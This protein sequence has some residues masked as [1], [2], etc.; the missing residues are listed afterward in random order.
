MKF[1]QSQPLHLTF[2]FI[3]LFFVYSTVLAQDATTS[4]EAM[5]AE[6]R[7]ER[8][9]ERTALRN[10]RRTTL[11]IELQERIINLTSNVTARLTAGIHR[12][13]NISDRLNS[14]IGKM[15]SAGIDTSAAE[16][17]LIEAN[18][19]LIGAQNALHDIEPIR[20]ALTSDTPKER[21]LKIRSEF[22]IV[23]EYLIQTRTHLQETV[24]LLKGAQG[25]F[26]QTST[27][28]GVATTTATTSNASN[29]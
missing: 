18:N 27:T 12:M 4:E 24:T 6:N 11:R 9:E 14:R 17:K 29:E 19:A 10:E 21:Y 8:I 5:P 3:G 23:R 15:K 22:L 28:N 2:I 1:L 26:S 13:T 20:N 16:A 25:G 7:T